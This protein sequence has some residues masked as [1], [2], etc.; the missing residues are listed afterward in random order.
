MF[1][2]FL[3]FLVRFRVMYRHHD[4]G[5]GTAALRKRNQILNR[6]QMLLFVHPRTVCMMSGSKHDEC[7]LR[8]W[9]RTSFVPVFSQ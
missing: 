4:G 2:I 1:V 7:C 8:T 5:K 6:A 9:V 3:L